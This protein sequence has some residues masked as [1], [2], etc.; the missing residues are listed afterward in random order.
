M[1]LFV[2]DRR[3]TGHYVAKVG[4]PPVTMCGNL[5]IRNQILTQFRLRYDLIRT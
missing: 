4:H 3:V 2:A 1:T 5:A